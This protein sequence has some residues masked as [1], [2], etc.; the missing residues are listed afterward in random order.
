LAATGLLVADHQIDH[1]FRVLSLVKRFLAIT[2]AQTALGVITGVISARVLGPTG[3]GDLAAIVVPLSLLPIVLSFGLPTLTSREVAGG[4]SLRALIGTAGVFAIVI[5]CVSIF[6]LTALLAGT[7]SQHDH[8]TR[9]VLIVGLCLMPYILFTNL[10]ADAA[11]GQQQWRLVTV[12]RLVPSVTTA[13]AYVALVLTHDLTAASAGAVVVGAGVLSTLPFVPVLRQAWPPRFERRIVGKARQIVGAAWILQSSQ[14]M[15]HRL[16]QLLMVS[17]VS[18]RQL[19][20]YAI[21]VTVSG[22]AGTLAPAVG[23]VVYP[24]MA[25]GEDLDVPRLVRQTLLAVGATSLITALAAPLVV[26]LAFGGAFR[27]AL[28]MLWILLIANLPLGGVGVLASIYT[29]RGRIGLASF[30]EVVAVAIT[31]VGL[32]LFL[33]SLGG[34]G[35]A[36][37][38]LAAYSV[39]FLWLLRMARNDFGGSASDYLLVPV[40]EMRIIARRLSARLIGTA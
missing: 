30:S 31:I 4:E 29:G 14:L 3:R 21:A 1:P 40:T 26:P 11:L 8:A 17:L 36:W 22:I 34:I 10:L 23:T 5:G 7:V 9:V 13:I 27:P 25:A 32:I 2:A 24:K 18:R 38:S 6:P 28:P 19:G 12:Q 39:N 20:L 15:N 16:D 35:A 37:V 33:P